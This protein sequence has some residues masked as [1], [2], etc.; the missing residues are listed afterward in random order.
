MTVSSSDF[1]EFV[2][3]RWPA[4]VRAA[5]L[6]GCSVP[7]AEDL[8]QSTLAKCYVHWGRVS[9]AGNPDKYVYTALL[10]QLR[11]SRRRR[12]WSER[13]TDEV[14][15]EVQPGAAD[16][17]RALLVQDALG[18]LSTAQRSVVIARHILDF[19]ESETAEILGVAP[20][21]VK[22]RLSRALALL[23]NDP[24]ILSI[25]RTETS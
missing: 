9:R 25:N 14:P 5:C 19:S 22:S 11:T 10:N 16:L 20:G 23:A 24:D 12:W 1:E 6:L 21:T 2:E 4:L 15:E 7:E 18:R 8:V 17:D 3:A 13:P